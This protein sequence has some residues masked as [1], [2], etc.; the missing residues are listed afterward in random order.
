MR[1]IIAAA[2]LVAAVAAPAP[3]AATSLTVNHELTGPMPADACL[4]RARETLRAAGLSLLQSSGNAAFAETG[5]YVVALY[6]IP[7]QGAIV[8]TAAG[9]EVSE[10]D[11]I[12]TR[13]LQAW[14]SAGA[15]AG[16]TK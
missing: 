4:A 3:G 15:A 9:P 12:V 6:C 16:P 8:V 13:V 5:D 11:P 7:A 1:S 10:T 2:A 14:R